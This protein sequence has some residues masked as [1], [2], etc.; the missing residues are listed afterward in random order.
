V[1]GWP[2]RVAERCSSPVGPRAACA[3]RR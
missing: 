1:R 3:S 2:L